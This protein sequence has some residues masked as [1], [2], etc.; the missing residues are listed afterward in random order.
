MKFLFDWEKKRNILG[1]IA[2]YIVSLLISILL[3]FVAGYLVSQGKSVAEAEKAGLMVGKTIA[4]VVP[5][6]LVGLFFKAKNLWKDWLAIVV[7]VLTV[8]LVIFGGGLIL[9]L[10]PVASLI[11]RKPKK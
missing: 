9:A 3:V 7:A 11:A 8:V 4:I 10:L 1:V 5:L 2:F 6:L